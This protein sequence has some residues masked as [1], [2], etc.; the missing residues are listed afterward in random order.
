MVAERGPSEG[1]VY[2]VDEDAASRDALCAAFAREGFEAEGFEG[3]SFLEAVRQAAP[4]CI[5][6]DIHVAERAGL[7]AVNRLHAERPDMPIFILSGRDE[8]ALAVRAVHEGAFDL[9]E[10][11]FEAE[12]AI[13]RV[14]Q[15]L[16]AAA[17]RADPKTPQ[18]RAFAGQELLTPRELEVV[19]QIATGASNEEAARRL[20][21]TPGTV[22]AHRARA[23]EKLEAKSTTDLV[24][25]VLSGT[26]Q[27]PYSR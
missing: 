3:V 5:L 15:A 11:P 2:V 21:L 8:I 7:A 22:D 4:A 27:R 23:M 17:R 16:A 24:R 13:D 18:L 20:G 1:S 9:I 10:K 12:A 14:R 26:D 25:I 19:D 6:L